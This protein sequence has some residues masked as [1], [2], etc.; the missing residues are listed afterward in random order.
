MTIY[1]CYSAQKLILIL[2]SNAVD[3]GVDVGIAAVCVQ[4]S[5]SQWLS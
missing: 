4:D 5:V 3:G 1:H 2:L